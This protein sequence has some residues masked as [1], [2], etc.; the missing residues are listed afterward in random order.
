M[1]WYN[2]TLLLVVIFQ[3]LSLD[4][5][6]QQLSTDISRLLIISLDGSTN[7][8]ILSLIEISTFISIRRVSSSVFQCSYITDIQS[9]PKWRRVCY[10]RNAT[11]IHY[12]DLS[13]SC[14]NCN[15]HVWWEDF[16]LFYWWIGMYQDQHGIIH[17]LFF[18][19]LLNKT[20]TLGL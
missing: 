3:I 5:A 10:K 20:I 11:Y 19:R 14:F 2:W 6:T 8:T 13:K 16:V 12:Y 7:K 9:I 1:L 15:R 18:D 4:D 17:N